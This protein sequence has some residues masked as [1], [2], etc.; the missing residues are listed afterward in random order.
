MNELKNYIQNSDK[1]NESFCSIRVTGSIARA[2]KRK[3][4]QSIGA[5]KKNLSSA[6]KNQLVRVQV[7]SGS[8]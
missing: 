3:N 7:Q 4:S 2:D 5:A 1:K 6:K 8:I